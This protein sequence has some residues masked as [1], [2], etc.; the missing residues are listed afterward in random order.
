MAAGVSNCNFSFTKADLLIF[1]LKK[2]ICHLFHRRDQI[3]PNFDSYDSDDY[4]NGGEELDNSVQYSNE[5]TQS[6]GS[7]YDAD[8]YEEDESLTSVDKRSH[9]VVRKFK[10]KK[11]GG[12]TEFK[13]Q[14]QGQLTEKHVDLCPI[15]PEKYKIQI[16]WRLRGYELLV[17][18]TERVCNH[19]TSSPG[20]D[21]QNNRVSGQFSI[22][23]PL[24]FGLNSGSSLNSF[25]S[26]QVCYS[27]G[28]T[29]EY[30]HGTHCFQRSTSREIEVKS[31]S[32]K[33]RTKYTEENFRDGCTCGWATY[34]LGPIEDYHYNKILNLCSELKDKV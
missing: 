9:L 20:Y 27:L 12:L 18:H 8:E 26:T 29:F 19:T 30:G 31:I 5:N 1:G 16:D 33:K 24:F 4:N 7:D 13:L 32:G 11:N 17:N 28:R 23:I 6:V 21:R 34:E 14:P 15:H 22:S 2:I 10:E 25:Q 3:K